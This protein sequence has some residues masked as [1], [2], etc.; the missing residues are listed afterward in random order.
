[1]C[2]AWLI[3]ACGMTCSCVAWHD[4]F[5]HASVLEHVWTCLWWVRGGGT[6]VSLKIEVVENRIHARVFTNTHT[7]KI[8][9]VIVCLRAHVDARLLPLP[10][11]ALH[12]NTTQ[13]TLQRNAILQHTLP[14]GF[15]STKTK[16]N[17]V[18]RDLKKRPI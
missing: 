17:Y 10:H 8:L 15:D 14:A 12:G 2:V 5:I 6:C 11:I 3:H 4:S 9:R 16:S 1:M 13:D 18:K 7:K